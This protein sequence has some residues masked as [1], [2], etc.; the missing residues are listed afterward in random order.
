MKIRFSIGRRI[1]LG[2]FVII[3]STV[4]A[5][6]TTFNTLKD[7]RE[8]D[9]KINNI[10]N[11]SLNALGEL[12]LLTIRSKMLIYN[13]VHYQSS[14]NN[15]DK[16]KLN[17]LTN[18]EYVELQQRIRNLESFWTETQMAEMEL[19]FNDM[20]TL[21]DLHQE[22]K[23]ML[24]SFESYDEPEN[25]FLANSMVDQ[26]GD[27]YMK[28]DEVLN[29]LNSIIKQQ[30]D[31]SQM[32]RDEMVDAFGLLQTLIISLGI[33]LIVAGIF[34]A[35]LTTR[36][37]VSP[38][39]FLRL[40]LL[41]LS[42]G[43]FPTKTPSI[44]NDEIGEMTV[45]L[46]KVVNGLKQTKD[47]AN[48]VGSGKYNTP[49]RPLS[50]EDELGKALLTMRTDLAENERLLED[51]VRQR[52]AEVVQ[53]KEEIE[54]Q[55]LKI[56]ELY[57]QVTDS[58]IYAKRIQEAILPAPSEL[59][60]LLPE[61]FVLFK[62]K[63][64]VS[65]DFYWMESL[66][67]QVLLA[68][69][70]CTGH[71]V[72]GAFMSIVSHNLLNGAVREQGLTEPAKIL[73]D[74]NKR[75]SDTL[76]TSAERTV[77]D[78]MDLAVV[79][80]TASKDTNM[81]QYAGAYNSLYLIREGELIEFKSNKIPIGN[82]YENTEARYTNNEISLQKGDAVY[83]FSDGYADQFGGPKG[84]KLKYSA[85]KQMLIDFQNQ[86]MAEQKAFLDNTI[87]S[88]KGEL[89]QVDDILVIGLQF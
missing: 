39:N 75:L 89:E 65:G 8:I 49:F 40:I 73:D 14:D 18:V 7:S 59:E 11:P 57:N 37:I 68:A 17:D 25:R 63:D 22:V 1:S 62:P 81:I 5:F 85:F 3:L 20:G 61:H 60:R 69:A 28:T 43:V 45:A 42:R 21:L 32:V 46:N 79:S 53:Q 35:V 33:G 36:S 31:N 15:P 48:D 30:Q 41:D 77:R 72:P 76:Q 83:I 56:A 47:F 64:I 58:I 88:W 24:N 34:I 12:K 54:L 19:V 50:E 51:K 55:S 6:I 86:S 66:G 10:T 4:V 78:G 84:K 80:F 27:I 82:Y 44:T 13:W 9:T 38:V 74:V 2:F 52:T 16:I 29:R 67:E 87:E 70:D 71:G 23:L 26:G